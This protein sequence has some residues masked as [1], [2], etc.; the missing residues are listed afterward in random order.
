MSGTKH[1]RWGIATWAAALVAGT[2]GMAQETP[3]QRG[4]AF[5]AANCAA[6]HAVERFGE[7]P[8]TEAPRFRDLHEA[9]PVEYLEE[10]LAEGI[11]TG[12]PEMPQ[13]ELPPDLIDDVIAYLKSLE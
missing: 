1:F 9:Y 5:V 13:F 8:L 4:H 11:L 12:H 7:S 3:E 2:Q 6:C 10:A